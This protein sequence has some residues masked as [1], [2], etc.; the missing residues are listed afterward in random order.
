MLSSLS[1]YHKPERQKLLS[2]QSRRCQNS[3]KNLLKGCSVLLQHLPC[4]QGVQ[5][6]APEGTTAIHHPRAPWPTHQCTA[7]SLGCY[8]SPGNL[9][10]KCL[11]LTLLKI[12]LPGSCS[13]K[14]LT[15]LQAL[16]SKVRPFFT[17]ERKAIL[18][19]FCYQEKLQ[20]FNG[21]SF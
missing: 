4:D 7:D 8:F 19:C 12:L 20:Q 17:Y 11:L 6:Q 2:L 13:R 16:K 1:N 10:L 14:L 18:W 5:P 15:L 3:M 9:H 21:S